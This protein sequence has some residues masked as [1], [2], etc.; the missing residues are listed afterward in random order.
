MQIWMSI[1]NF[2]LLD[3]FD[4][5]EDV[6]AYFISNHIKFSNPFFGCIFVCEIIMKRLWRLKIQWAVRQPIWH[7]K[8]AANAFHWLQL[9]FFALKRTSVW[10]DSTTPNF[11]LFMLTYQLVWSTNS[12][13]LMKCWCFCDVWPLD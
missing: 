9:L 3:P 11:M 10:Y 5:H 12:G 2:Q 4:F 7:I 8:I 13:V 6:F 1:Q